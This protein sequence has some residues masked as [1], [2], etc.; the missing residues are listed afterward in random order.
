MSNDG[1]HSYH[2]AQVKHALGQLRPASAKHNLKDG[3]D[4][5]ASYRL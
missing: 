1:M 5:T 2:L 4:E 3:T